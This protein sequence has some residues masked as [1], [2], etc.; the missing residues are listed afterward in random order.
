VHLSSDVLP[1]LTSTWARTDV[2]LLARMF[3]ERREGRAGAD[4]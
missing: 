3:M 1:D 4:S 2:G